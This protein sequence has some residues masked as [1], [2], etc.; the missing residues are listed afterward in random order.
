MP[1]N[2]PPTTAKTIQALSKS[3][4][5]TEVSSSMEMGLLLG[6]ALEALKSVA[7]SLHSF[8]FKLNESASIG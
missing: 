6:G 5:V 2:M 1:P 8:T 3:S 7:R 4:R